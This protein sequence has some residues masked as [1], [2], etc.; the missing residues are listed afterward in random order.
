MVSNTNLYVNVLR[1]RAV[2]AEEAGVSLGMYFQHIYTDLSPN[3]NMN[4]SNCF[5]RSL[6]I[7]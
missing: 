6:Y 4:L 7:Y 1:V 5:I 3:S 2:V